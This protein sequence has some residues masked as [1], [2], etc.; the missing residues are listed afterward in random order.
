MR[1]AITAPVE[2]STVGNEP[3][4]LSAKLVRRGAARLLIRAPASHQQPQ[5]RAIHMIA[6][7]IADDL[8]RPEH[9]HPVAQIDDFI[10][11]ERHE[12]HA[13][14]LIALPHQLAMDEFDRADI[15]PARR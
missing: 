12:Q 13:A 15:E 9:K 8:A 2:A 14:L 11:I 1:A 10:E 7:K 5:R 3:R 4:A 6:W